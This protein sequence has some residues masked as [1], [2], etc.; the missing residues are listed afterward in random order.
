MAVEFCKKK[1]SLVI[2]REARPR[3][4]EIHSNLAT[5]DSGNVVVA[6]L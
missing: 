2:P 5:R 6:G 4:V 1:E 3:R